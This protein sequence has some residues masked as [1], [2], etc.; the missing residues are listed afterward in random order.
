MKL[1]HTRIHGEL[2]D[3]TSSA[4]DGRSHPLHVGRSPQNIVLNFFNITFTVHFQFTVYEPTKYT[5]TFNFLIVYNFSPTYV[6][7]YTKTIIRG[8]QTTLY[9]HP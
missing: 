5:F 1:T 4:K 3:V 6:S 8:T 7:V 2:D 9:L